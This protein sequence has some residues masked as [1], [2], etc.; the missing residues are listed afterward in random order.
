MLPDALKAMYRSAGEVE[1]HLAEVYSTDISR[2][3][4]SKITDRVL[5]DMARKREPRS[6]VWRT[7]EHEPKHVPYH[8]CLRVCCRLTYRRRQ[9]NRQPGRGRHRDVAARCEPCHAGR[10]PAGH[11]HE[12]RPDL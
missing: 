4:I 10:F 9:R 3:T 12:R 2:E 11:H 6:T 5:G 1:A 7:D 8:G